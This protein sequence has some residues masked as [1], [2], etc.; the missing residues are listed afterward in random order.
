MISDLSLLTEKIT[1]FKIGYLPVILLFIV[2]GWFLFYLRWDLL[3]RNLKIYIPIKENMMIYFSG[4]AMG[5]TPGRIGEIFKSQLLKEKYGISR[6]KTAPLVLVERL[7]DTIGAIAAAS[8]GIFI[9]PIVGYAIFPAVVIIGIVFAIISSKFTFEKILSILK[10][11]KPLNNLLEPLHDSYETIKTS[12]TGVLAFL[13]SVISVM[14]WLA[15]SLAV[16]FIFVAY[17]IQSV[18]Y[19]RLVSPFTAS[20][21]LGAI[22]FIPGGVG[23]TEGSFAGFL[24]LLKV[25]NSSIIVLVILVR[26]FTLWLGVLVGFIALKIGGLSSLTNL[27]R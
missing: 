3:L 23:V 12:T 11:I 21:I 22:S 19:L 8:V 26:I 25:E 10:K 6:A 13:S 24:K 16:Y 14:S 9:F 2:T 4:F 20:S 7:Y 1:H 15:T 5:F 27:K 17:G 18:D